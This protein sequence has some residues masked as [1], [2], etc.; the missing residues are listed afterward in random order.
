MFTK[1]LCPKKFPE[2]KFWKKKLGARKKPKFFEYFS[3]I[4]LFNF[5]KGFLNC[6]TFKPAFKI[7]FKTG[8]FLNMLFQLI[9]KTK[10][11]KTL[12]ICFYFAF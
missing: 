5:Q 11:L 4:K 2:K 3:I 6:S 8:K 9:S 12:K 1:N 10:N 7:I